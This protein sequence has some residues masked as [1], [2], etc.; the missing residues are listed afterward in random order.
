MDASAAD[1]AEHLTQADL[2]L[3]SGVTLVA[4]CAKTAPVRDPVTIERLLGAS[5]LA[6]GHSWPYAC[7]LALCLPSPC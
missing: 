7:R 6:T 1:Y 3:L 2:R 4:Y 5:G